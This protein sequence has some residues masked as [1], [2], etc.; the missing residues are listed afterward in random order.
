MSLYIGNSKLH[1]IGLLQSLL[2]AKGANS[3]RRVG[4]CV[5]TQGMGWFAMVFFGLVGPVL[6]LFGRGI[7]QFNS[8]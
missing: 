7:R 8:L 4:I 5:P 6:G 3:N 2:G 1:I